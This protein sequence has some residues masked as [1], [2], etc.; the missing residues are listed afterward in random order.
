MAINSLLANKYAIA[1]FKVASSANVIDKFEGDLR[2]F[3]SILSESILKEL[4][5]P[6]ISREHL[7][8]II[9]DLSS[10]LS[11]NEKVMS[12]L[13]VVARERRI[14]SIAAIEKSFIKLV[15][16]EKNILEVEIISVSALDDQNVEEIKEI[17]AKKYDG[18]SLEIHQTINKDI[19]GGV[20]IKIGSMMID[21]SL[22]RQL[23]ALNQQFQSIL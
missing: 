14:S 16:K 11:L 2:K 4:S 19:L 22:K 9:S 8:E 1:A 5:N 3:V 18:S 17:L 12:F 10:K 20:Q 6:A 15:K 7:V 23:T 21:A 13:E